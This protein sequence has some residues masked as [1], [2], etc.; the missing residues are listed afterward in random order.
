MQTIFVIK[1]PFLA[2]RKIVLI[3]SRANWHK[4]QKNWNC[5]TQH[6]LTH[7]LCSHQV[8][9]WREII[10]QFFRFT[11][12]PNGSSVCDE[13][14][15]F[16]D[17]NNEK[18]RT[19]LPVA[20]VLELRQASRQQWGWRWQRLRRPTVLCHWKHTFHST[21]FAAFWP[22]IKRFLQCSNVPPLLLLLLLK[23]HRTAVWHCIH[24]STE[25]I[26]CSF[27]L[28]RFVHTNTK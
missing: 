2:N 8:F 13:Q 1:F 9:S 18:S 16:T 25:W 3:F 21:P 27:F 15:M 23:R 7:T 17:G 19:G 20:V 5:S 28:P 4:L 22:P 26:R 10:K 6:T 12:D 24:I 14:W 11:T